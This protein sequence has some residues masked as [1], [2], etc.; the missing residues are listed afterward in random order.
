M[1]YIIS[2]WKNYFCMHGGE[3]QWVFFIARNLHLLFI[4]LAKY[5]IP[6]L[7]QKIHL[8]IKLDHSSSPFSSIMQTYLPLIHCYMSNSLLSLWIKHWWIY[9]L[10]VRKYVDVH[11]SLKSGCCTKTLTNINTWIRKLKP[12]LTITCKCLCKNNIYVLGM[13]NLHFLII[14]YRKIKFVYVKNITK[15][16]GKW[17]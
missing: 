14:F 9:V 17:L 12:F 3:L 4:R 6:W 7:E 15:Q 11:F 8:R 13:Y 5:Q 10:N 2:F 1:L 16:T